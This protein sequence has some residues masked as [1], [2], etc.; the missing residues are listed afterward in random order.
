MIRYVFDQLT[1]QSTHP[2]TSLSDLP[3]RRIHLPSRA[4]QHRL[5]GRFQRRHFAD[6]RWTLLILPHLLHA[7][8]VAPLHWRY[9]WV[10]PRYSAK[11][12]SALGSFQNPRG[13]RNSR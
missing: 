4:D 13:F 12:G 11:D 7:S 9:W 6:G 1:D 8:S 10:L 2:V 5:L 3:H